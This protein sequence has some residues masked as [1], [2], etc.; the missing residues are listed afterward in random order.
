MN[1]LTALR[2]LRDRL[3]RHPTPSQPPSTYDTGHDTTPNDPT[4]TP[5][6][7]FPHHYHPMPHPAT[8]GE[9]NR[10]DELLH[11][12]TEIARAAAAGIL[13]EGNHHLLDTLIDHKLPQWH[14][15]IDHARTR[16]HHLTDGLI[17]TATYYDKQ[18]KHDLD[19]IRATI[20]TLRQENTHNRTHLT[21]HHPTP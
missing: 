18:A 20:Q 21:G 9:P 1:P 13:D 17:A 6:T 4:G 12:D 15:A 3:R 16:R 19:R 8:T 11:I 14:T 10:A 5:A 7:G 2:R